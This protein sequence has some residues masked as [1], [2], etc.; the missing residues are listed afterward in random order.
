MLHRMSLRALVAT[1]LS[2]ALVQAAAPDYLVLQQCAVVE[3]EIFEGGGGSWRRRREGFCRPPPPP[4]P[5]PPRTTR[6]AG[7]LAPPHAQAAAPPRASAGTGVQTPARTR[8]A[9]RRSTPASAPQRECRRRRRRRRCCTRGPP[10]SA[11]LPGLC[12]PPSSP[13]AAAQCAH[14]HVPWTAGAPLLYETWRARTWTGRFLT[15]ASARPS[16]H[17]RSRRRAL[18]VQP[19]HARCQEGRR[20][21]RH[22]LPCLAFALRTLRRA[23]SLAPAVCVPEGIAAARP[24]C[25][26]THVHLAPIHGTVGCQGGTG[27]RPAG[28]GGV[29]HHRRAAQGPVGGEPGRAAP[30]PTDPAAVPSPPRPAWA[31]WRRAAA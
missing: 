27:L 18:H 2:G 8:P 29:H 1:L 10:P 26:P 22:A 3:G 16:A 13:A 14:D 12:R 30:Q 17:H 6:P 19:C 24:A 28:R 31:V 5:P 9:P 15:S 11:A 20:P 4:P 7:L 23:Q 25:P 21:H